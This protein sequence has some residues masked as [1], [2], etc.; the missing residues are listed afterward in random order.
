M[1]RDPER[2]IEHHRPQPG[3]ETEPTGLPGETAVGAVQARRAHRGSP[4]PG[5]L[6]CAGRGPRARIGVDAGKKGDAF[7][8]VAQ[9]LRELL[10]AVWAAN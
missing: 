2:L 8:Q 4:S 7:E 1:R 6:R 5:R 10:G 9:A 3:D